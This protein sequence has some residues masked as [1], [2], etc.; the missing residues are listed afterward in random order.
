MTMH[1]STN[2]TPLHA[3]ASSTPSITTRSSSYFALSRIRV[4]TL[5]I[6]VRDDPFIAVEP[7]ETVKVSEN[8]TIQIVAHGGHLGFVGWDGVGGIR[9]ADRRLVGWLMEA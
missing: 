2:S 7:F 6:T 8:V 1:S 5:I 4:K 3:V 9:W